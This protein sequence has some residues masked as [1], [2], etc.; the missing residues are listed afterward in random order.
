[1]RARSPSTAAR[2]EIPQDYPMSVQPI[3][4]SMLEQQGLARGR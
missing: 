3:D 2:Q 1:M 4:F